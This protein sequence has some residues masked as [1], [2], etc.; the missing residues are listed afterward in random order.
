MQCLPKVCDLDFFWNGADLCFIYFHDFSVKR[1]LMWC[2][3]GVLASWSHERLCQW[4]ESKGDYFVP[5][6]DDVRITESDGG[7]FIIYRFS[8]SC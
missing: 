3:A 8:F 7:Q 1:Y 4:L 5:I 2:M 6:L